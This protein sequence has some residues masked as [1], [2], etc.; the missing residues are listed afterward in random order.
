LNITI[1]YTQTE[2]GLVF[3]SRLWILRSLLVSHTFR[4]YF[5]YF[6]CLRYLQWRSQPKNLGGQN[7]WF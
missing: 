3:K 1:K 6:C 5:S 7:V 4:H 2:R